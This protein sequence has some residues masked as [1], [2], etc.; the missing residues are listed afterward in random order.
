LSADPIK[1]AGAA[2]RR[3]V[4]GR[5]PFLLWALLLTLAFAPVLFVTLI[6]AA[7]PELWAN[8]VNVVLGLCTLAFMLFAFW[9]L[10][11]TVA[12]YRDRLGDPFA[13]FGWTLVAYLPVFAA[14]LAMWRLEIDADFIFGDTM[15]VAA[16][17]FAAP[18]LVHASGRAI[19]QHGPELNTIWQQWLP[20]YWALV[21]AYLLVTLPF[22]L[23][24]DIIW[25]FSGS[26]GSI[27]LLGK[28]SAAL[29]ST[30]GSVFAVALTVE[31]FHRAEEIHVS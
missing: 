1:L 6:E 4:S 12:N 7:I 31:A 20:N 18:I 3:L 19:D 11:R 29:L 23:V 21:G 28:L 9:K 26:N 22:C 8:A 30:F 25:Y 27:A 24:A 10:E 16:L 2:T 5:V 14:V 13:W 17:S 15:M